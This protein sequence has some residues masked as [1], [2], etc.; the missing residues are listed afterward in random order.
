MPK[1]GLIT[2]H[3][4]GKTEKDYSKPFLDDMESRV[5]ASVWEKVAIEE[6]FYQDILQPNEEA[7]FN[8]VKRRLRWDSLRQFMLYGICDAASLESQKH[9]ED[10]PYFL[11]QKEILSKFRSAYKNLE[12]GAPLIIIAQSLGGQVISNYI[13]DAMKPDAPRA[14]VWSDP[15]NF[16]SQGEE[17]FCRCTSLQYLNTTGCNIPLFVAGRASS[18]IEPIRKPNPKFEWHNLYDKDDVLGWPLGDLSPSY[19][20]LVKDKPINSGFLTSMT[21]LSHR[22]YWNDR[23]V[24]KPLA[25]AIKK[26]TR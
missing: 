24:Q 22:E 18:D 21:P 5:G 20:N 15:P 26:L 9:G 6:V 25:A 8:S 23:D 3:G 10:S 1:I 19:K 7:Y 11:A 14:G 16:T 17:D 13:W 12:P 2:V 4:M